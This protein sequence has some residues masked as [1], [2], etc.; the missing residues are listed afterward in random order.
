[1][2]ATEDLDARLGARLEGAGGCQRGGW[3][4]QRGKEV[5]GGFS[6]VQDSAPLSDEQEPSAV[7]LGVLPPDPAVPL[8]R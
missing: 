5:V 6:G 4:V 2:A 8:H 1:M 7:A 3:M